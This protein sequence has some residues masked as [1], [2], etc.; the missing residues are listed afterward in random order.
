MRDLSMA[1]KLGWRSSWWAA[2]EP[3]FASLRARNDFQA[4]IAQISRS[5]DR[6]T[7]KLKVD[8]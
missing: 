8:Q 3:Y 5:N 4:L 2:H 6:L 1:A 7:E